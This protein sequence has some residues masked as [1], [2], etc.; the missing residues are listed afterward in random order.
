MRDTRENILP[1]FIKLCAET[2][3]LVSH[4]GAQ[5]CRLE[6]NKNICLSV[7]LVLGGPHKD[8]DTNLYSE[9]KKSK[10]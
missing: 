1:K 9:E 8:Y 5:I 3:S 2:P 4:R 10:I 6:T 7:F